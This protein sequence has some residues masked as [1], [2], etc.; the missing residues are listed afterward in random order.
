MRKRKTKRYILAVAVVVLMVLSFLTGVLAS[1]IMFTIGDDTP[2]SVFNIAMAHPGL[3][4]FTLTADGGSA[5]AALSGLRLNSDAS[6]VVKDE[7]GHWHQTISVDLFRAEYTNGS[8]EVI[9][10][11]D[12]GDKVVAPGAKNSYYFD[13]MNTGDVPIYYTMEAHA[14]AKFTMGDEE[15]HIPIKVKMYN[16]NGIYLVGTENSY[17]DISE[18]VNIS[19]NGGISLDRYSRYTLDWEWPFE[20]NDD[21]DTMLGNLVADM[22]GGGIEDGSL[23]VESGVLEVSVEMEVTAV[24]DPNASGGAAQTSDNITVAILMMICVFAIFVLV[25]LL[26]IYSRDDDDFADAEQS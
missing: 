2:R 9:I 14:F 13:I 15:H 17:A 6:A 5:F 24:E 12:N 20:G 25:V 19:N 1:D 23:T 22:D 4:P 3:R 11:S 7:E 8:G 18:L 10:K 16:A 26:G 21:F